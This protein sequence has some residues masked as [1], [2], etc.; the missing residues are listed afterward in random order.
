M[1]FPV[2]VFGLGLVAMSLAVLSSPVA[3]AVPMV[4]TP[5][6]TAVAPEAPATSSKAQIEALKPQAP[7][8]LV[9]KQEFCTRLAQSFANI[10]ASS[11]FDRVHTAMLGNG[12]AVQVVE[13]FRSGR[14]SDYMRAALL[15]TIANVPAVAGDNSYLPISSVVGEAMGVGSNAALALSSG[16]L[17]YI[18]A[19]QHGTNLVVIAQNAASLTPER[20]Q[21]VAEIARAQEIHVS[22]VWVGAGDEGQD[23]QDA[24]TLGWLAAVTGGAFANLGGQISPCGSSL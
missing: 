11:G 3:F 12:A 6:V 2:E 15:R 18:P 8:R 13:D 7:L 1:K 14:A 9:D 5:V 16:E 24:R 22:I 19:A 17:R 23:K 21:K 10:G 4:A 20:A